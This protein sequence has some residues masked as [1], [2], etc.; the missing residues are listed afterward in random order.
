M[1]GQGEDF[2]PVATVHDVKA[3]LPDVPPGA[4]VNVRVTAAN[5]TGESQP[6]ET[7]SAVAG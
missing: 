4:T 2:Q 7:V 3:R 6:G 1:A 5:E